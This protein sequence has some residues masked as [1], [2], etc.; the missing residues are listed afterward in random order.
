MLYNAVYSTMNFDNND[1]MIYISNILILF[2]KTFSCNIYIFFI[3]Q[4]TNC[5][6]CRVACVGV[7]NNLLKKK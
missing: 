7:S 4:K 1:I 2:L 5:V 3:I 6:R